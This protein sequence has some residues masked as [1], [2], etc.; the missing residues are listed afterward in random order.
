LIGRLTLTDVLSNSNAL[1][2]RRPPRPPPRPK[3]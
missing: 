3:L 2:L 1:F